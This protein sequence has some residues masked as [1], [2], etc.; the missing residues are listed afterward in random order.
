MIK[1]G[2]IEMT[3]SKTLDPLLFSVTIVVT[4]CLSPLINFSLN[5]ASP[6][7]IFLKMVAD[8]LISFVRHIT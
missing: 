1:I 2:F 6:W 5:C 4:G 8:C 7:V 3:G